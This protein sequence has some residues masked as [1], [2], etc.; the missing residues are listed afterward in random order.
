EGAARIRCHDGARTGAQPEPGFPCGPRGP[1]GEELVSR[2]RKRSSCPDAKA[3]VRRLTFLW[4]MFEQR[5]VVE[6]ERGWRGL[7]RLQGHGGLRSRGV[8]PNAARA[9]ERANWSTIG[10]FRGRDQIQSGLAGW[11]HSRRPGDW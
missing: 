4:R 2:Y 7:E 8:A 9:A 5:S 11:L 10:V 6:G 3:L 1:C